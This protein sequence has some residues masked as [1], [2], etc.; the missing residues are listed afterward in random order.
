M[1]REQGPRLG[2]DATDRDWLRPS[3]MATYEPT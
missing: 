1:S 3:T 2:G